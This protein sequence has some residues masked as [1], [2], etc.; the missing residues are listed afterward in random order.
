M[1]VGVAPGIGNHLEQVCLAVGVAIG[2]P[3]HLTALAHIEGIVLVGQT[4]NLVE[5]GGE[6]LVFRVGLFL[7]H[8]GK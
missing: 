3:G 4:E 2:Y 5:A 7:V 8:A 6:K 1:V